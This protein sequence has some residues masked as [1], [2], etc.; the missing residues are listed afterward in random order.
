MKPVLNKVQYKKYAMDS[1]GRLVK[2][3]SQT[4]EGEK[5][6]E[7]KVWGGNLYVLSLSPVRYYV[8]IPPRSEIE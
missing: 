3:Y 4:R 5:K 6:K 8:D 7:K 1:A 2:N